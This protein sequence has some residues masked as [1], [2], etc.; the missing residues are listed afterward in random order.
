MKQ[1]TLYTI[2]RW[3][4]GGINKNLYSGLFPYSSQ[5]DNPFGVSLKNDPTAIVPHVNWDNPMQRAAVLGTTKAMS[6]GFMDVA[7][8]NSPFIKSKTNTPNA[9]NIAKGVFGAVAGTAGN[10]LGSAIRGG[11]DTGGVGKG[12]AAVGN[13]IGGALQAI[14]GIGTLAGSII[15]FG[16][17]LVGGAIDRLWGKRK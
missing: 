7:S 2:N 1:N 8:A 11:Y 3:N 9:S 4:K 17:G 6:D 10:L 13:T 12:V 15:Q 16:S 5:M 14:P